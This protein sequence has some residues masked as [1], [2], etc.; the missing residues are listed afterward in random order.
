[1]GYMRK[2][3]S[4]LIEILEVFHISGFRL[5]GKT[6]VWV[7][8]EGD[9]GPKKI[10]S[11]GVKVDAKGISRHGFVLNVN[12]DMAYWEG[13]MPCGLD[14]VDMV[15]MKDL[16]RKD[17]NLKAVENELVD[18]FEGVFERVMVLKENS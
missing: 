8:F 4:V 17:F 15:S 12:P 16:L 10:I 9:V 7:K 2:L 13:I 5:E 11:I 18:R 6:G 3:E 14:G 1:M